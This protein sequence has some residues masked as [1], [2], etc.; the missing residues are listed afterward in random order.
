[1]RI[2]DVRGIVVA[3]SLDDEL[4][5]LGLLFPR[6][7]VRVRGIGCWFVHVGRIG[8]CAGQ[9]YQT[10][11]ARPIKQF[12]I[13]HVLSDELYPPRGAGVEYQILAGLLGAEEVEQCNGHTIPLT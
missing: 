3:R 4:E 6:S 12:D 10:N 11:R 8:F 9:P 1:M 5:R 13:E 2:D 7:Q